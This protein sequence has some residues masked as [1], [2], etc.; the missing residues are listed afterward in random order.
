[1]SKTA[2]KRHS[3]ITPAEA[4]L[5][6]VIRALDADDSERDTA[7][8]VAMLQTWH[9]AFTDL[10]TNG[11]L[12][13]DEAIARERQMTAAPAETVL[14]RSTLRAELLQLLRSAVRGR[15]AGQESSPI[16]ITEPVAF[17]V[18]LEDADEWLEVPGF[19]RAS[20]AA[21][22]DTR[23]LIILQLLLL[24]QE[25]GIGN[26]HECSAPDCRRLYVKVYRREFCGERCQKRINTRK[27]RANAKAKRE[28]AARRRRQQRRKGASA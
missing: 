1:M 26:V 24:L 20:I 25:V 21:E 12:R 23:S 28:R 14:E 22:G 4:T 5:G 2:R 17:R 13:C 8:T 7:A 15:L 19:G 9:A 18:R 3:G 16:T 11:P 10:L 27:Q 6:R